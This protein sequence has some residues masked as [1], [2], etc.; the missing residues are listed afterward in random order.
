[1]PR[2]ARLVHAIAVGANQHSKVAGK[3]PRI[4]TKHLKPRRAESGRWELSSFCMDGL[5]ECERWLLLAQYVKPDVVARAEL[6]PS[7]VQDA[8]LTLDVDWNPERHVNIVG[9]PE[10]EIEQVSMAQVL[11][12]RQVC[13]VR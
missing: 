7:D 6:L 3:P 5:A 1:M 11:S 12:D 2:S 8:T 10:L 9:W 4:R 13:T